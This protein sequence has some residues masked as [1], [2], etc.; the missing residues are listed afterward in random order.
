MKLHSQSQY[1]QLPGGCPW[2]FSC[3]T[4]MSRTAYHKI[5][6]QSFWSFQY[7]KTAH[8]L[9]MST[10]ISMTI[11]WHWSGSQ[12]YHCVVI[13]VILTNKL[14]ICTIHVCKQEE[15]WKTATPYLAHCP[16]T[17]RCTIGWPTYCR[18]ICTQGCSS[19]A[20]LAFLRGQSVAGRNLSRV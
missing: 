5:T 10:L 19:G 18:P 1:H 9:Y 4:F 17:S 11:S 8:N 2:H 3:V 16:L 12:S 15:R 13:I 6:I 14:H 20:Q 7:F